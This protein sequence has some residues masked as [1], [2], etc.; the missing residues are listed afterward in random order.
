[1]KFSRRTFIFAA[2]IAGVTA[3]AGTWALAGGPRFATEPTAVQIR[4]TPIASFD[5]SD[6]TRV[7][8]GALEFRG[9]LALTSDFAAFGGISGLHVDAD[10]AHILAVTDNGSWLKARMVYRDGRLDGLA[11]AEMAPLL[12]E[13]GKPLAMQRA[14]DSES[15][16]QI[17]D[18]FY[19]GIERIERI[20][21]FAARGGFA[22]RGNAIATPPDFKSFKFNKSLECLASPPPGQ[23]YAGKLIA[24]TEESL[25]EAGNHRS[26]VLDPAARN[27]AGT[28]RFTV[29]RSDDFDI[30]DCT[31]LPPGDLL[32]L[33]RSY[34]P[35]RGVAM[36]IRRVP[37]T[38]IKE[39]AVVDGPVLIK[40]DL[41]Y[42]IDNMEGVAV[43]RN[44][45]GE[46]IITLV[47]DD[48]FS[49]IQRN[50]MLQFAL[51]E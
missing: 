7:R 35:L 33:E 51:V 41:G 36:R 49:A 24:V 43:T 47:S 39:G 11:D 46:T 14:Y 2:L 10:G 15:L 19:V 22:A 48:N 45:A 31:I 13:N 38:D 34:S 30:S 25:D 8:F 17:G 1:M 4:A 32:L 16:A 26:F 21:R 42:Q 44:A 28:L 18:A 20:E 29:K 50:I 3:V 9:G 12:G 27:A 40:A 23:P 37:V 5:N 6:P